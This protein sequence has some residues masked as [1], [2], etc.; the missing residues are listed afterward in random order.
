MTDKEFLEEKI[1]QTKEYL[2]Y[3]MTKYDGDSK[4]YIVDTLLD[5]I[6]QAKRKLNEM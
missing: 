6:N 1:R 2:L 3:I 5:A 4:E